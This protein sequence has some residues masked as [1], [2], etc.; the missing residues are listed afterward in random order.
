MNAILYEKIQIADAV[1]PPHHPFVV[2]AAQTSCTARQ[3]PP[4]P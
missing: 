4:R 1:G 2:Q 3:T